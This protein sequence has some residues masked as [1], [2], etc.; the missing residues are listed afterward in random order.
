MPGSNVRRCQSN[1]SA[2]VSGLRPGKL[3]RQRTTGGRALDISGTLT[4]TAGH[5][6]LQAGPF[7]VT[8]GTTLAPA[9]PNPSPPP[10]TPASPT[11][12]GHQHSPC[13]AA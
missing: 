9:T 10:S 2:Q 11:A 1:I 4:L 12:P 8:L 3:Q 7:P 5:G 6:G 13:K